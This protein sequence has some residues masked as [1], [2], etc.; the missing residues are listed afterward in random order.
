MINTASNQTTQQLVLDGVYQHFKDEAVEVL[1]KLSM[2]M[3]RIIGGLQPTPADLKAIQTS[4]KWLLQEAVNTGVAEVENAIRQFDRYIQQQLSLGV[5]EAIIINEWLEKLKA[6]II[7]YQIILP[8]DAASQSAP[9]QHR[10]PVFE[11]EDIVKQQ[12]VIV[13][14][15]SD[16]TSARIVERELAA[17]GFSV[18]HIADPDDAKMVCRQ[19]TPDLIICNVTLSKGDGVQLSQSFKPTRP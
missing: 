14:I 11:I 4:S 2:R 13:L 18:S 5:R 17:C 15:V 19:V 12:I 8:T 10:W 7:H 9:V 6:A 3:D 1:S 16:R